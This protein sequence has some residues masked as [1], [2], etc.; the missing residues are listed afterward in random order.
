MW[1]GDKTYYLCVSCH[2]PHE[3]RFKQIKPMP[4]PVRPAD[5]K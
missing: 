4:P 3:P 2:W 1:N 5:I